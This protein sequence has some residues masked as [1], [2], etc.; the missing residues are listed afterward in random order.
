MLYNPLA[1]LFIIIPLVLA[2]VLMLL[3][4]PKSRR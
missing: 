1:V 3:P 4:V 2:L